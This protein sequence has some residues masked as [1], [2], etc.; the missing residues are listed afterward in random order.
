MA[1][2]AN[3]TLSYRTLKPYGVQGYLKGKPRAQWGSVVS[4][5]QLDS[6]Q[7]LVLGAHRLK[8]GCSTGL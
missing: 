2:V 6:K 5:I 8:M 1:K 4:K 3:A 7:V